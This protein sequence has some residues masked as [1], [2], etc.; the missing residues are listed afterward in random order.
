MKREE[1][2]EYVANILYNADLHILILDIKKNYFWN[3]I[4]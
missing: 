3:V 1:D 4:L 2:K